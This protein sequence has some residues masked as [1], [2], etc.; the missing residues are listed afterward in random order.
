[1]AHEH[2]DCGRG[3]IEDRH[4]EILDQPPVGARVRVVGCPF[5]DDDGRPDG[6]RAVDDVAVAGDPPGVG[7]A[8]EDIA[9]LD[10][11]VVAG[12]VVGPDHVAAAGMDDTLRCAGRAARVEDEERVFRIHH[13]RRA[14]RC[15]PG[16]KIGVVDLPRGVEVDGRCPPPEDDG[17]F[18]ARRVGERLV[19]DIAERDGLSPPVADICGDDDLCLRIVDPH[20]E[21]ARAET[22]EDHRMDGPEPR[23]GKHRD[24]LLG[25][26]R[27]V[28]AD[29][30]A[31][32]DAEARKGVC[33][34][35]HLAVEA[36]VGEPPLFPALAA[37]YDRR[38]IPAVARDVAVEA[39]VGDVEFSVDEP[40]RVG[41]VPL[42]NPIPGLE[43]VEFV[44]DLVP[45]GLRVVHELLVRPGV[46]RRPGG[47]LAPGVGE[48]A[49]LLQFDSKCLCHI[50]SFPSSVMPGCTA[51]TRAGSGTVQCRSIC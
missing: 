11:E 37:P 31:F 22:A 12:G 29:P 36:V 49:L 23:A 3:G 47:R 13:L 25:D 48:V 10:V 32:P 28:N 19:H 1:M 6:K 34:P 9:L 39:V 30:V 20:R 38:F 15:G 44:G 16:H 42:K 45:E 26:E 14:V 40:L 5:G 2:A 51:G 17:L 35:H 21:R 24:D 43:P 46:V 7:G 50:S 4:P 33:T 8:P 18:D 41:V 27:H